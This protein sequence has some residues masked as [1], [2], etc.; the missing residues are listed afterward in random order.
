MRNITGLIAG[1]VVL[2][3]MALMSAACA[4][5]VVNVWSAVMPWMGM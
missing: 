5:L 4:S 3:F 1:L 2:G